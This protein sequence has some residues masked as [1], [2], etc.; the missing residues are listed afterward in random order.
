MC[1]EQVREQHLFTL[2]PCA[3]P[4]KNTIK[5]DYIYIRYILYR[6]FCSSGTFR[7]GRDELQASVSQSPVHTVAPSAPVFN[8]LCVT[9]QLPSTISLRQTHHLIE[10]GSCF[11]AGYS[12]AVLSVI[13]TV[14]ELKKLWRQSSI[15]TSKQTS[16]RSQSI[17]G[18]YPH[19]PRA[20]VL[21]PCGC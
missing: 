2:Q 17:C 8:Y 21:F 13:S 7:P 16:T 3:F 10:G 6:T 14:S 11:T 19:L 9:P 20:D 18:D 5:F 12:Q 15:T 1:T 4:Y